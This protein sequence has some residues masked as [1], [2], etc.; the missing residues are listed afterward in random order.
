MRKR[1]VVGGIHGKKYSWIGHEDRNRHKNRTERMWAS[2][3]G[4]CQKHKPQHPHHLKVSLR[5]CT[6]AMYIFFFFFKSILL[7][8]DIALTAKWCGEFEC[9]SE[10]QHIGYFESEGKWMLSHMCNPLPT[11]RKS[12]KHPPLKKKLKAQTMIFNHW[13]NSS[14]DRE[15]YFP[16][17]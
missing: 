5:E 7:H 3:A 6:D 2:S 9:T 10:P 8:G 4:L 14:S 12:N 13:C 15:I 1:R 16:F 17:T 11:Q